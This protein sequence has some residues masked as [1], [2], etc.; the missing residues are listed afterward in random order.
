MRSV[1]AGFV[2]AGLLLVACKN[3]TSLTG[4][5]GGAGGTGGT[6]GAG[7]S[8]ELAKVDKVDLL[9][10]IDNSRSMAD[11]QTILSLALSDLVSGLANPPCLDETGNYVSQPGALSPCPEGSSRQY[12]PVRDIHIGVVTSSLGGHGSDAC[13]AKPGNHNDDRAHLITRTPADDGSN[14]PTYQDLGFLAWDPE[15]SLAPPGLADEALLV[16]RF[17]DLVLGVGQTG[18]GFEAQ[19]ESWYR[20]LV[21]PDPPESLVVNQPGEVEW[22][23]SDNVLLAQ[24]KAFLRPDSMLAIVSMSDENDCSIREESAYYYVAQAMSGAGMFHLPKARAICETDPAHECCYSCAGTSPVDA[25]GN[26]VCEGDPTCT[27]MFGNVPYHD[28][29]TD[30]INQRCFDQKRRFGIDF[31]YPLDRYV[32]GLT[33]KLVP[34]RNGNLVDNPLFKDLD[35]TDGEQPVRDAG[36]VLLTGIVGVPWQDIAKNP[37]DLKQGFK[38]AGE[39]TQ[40]NAAGQTTWDI[41][42]GDPA[43]YTLPLDPFMQESIF[44]RSGQNPVTGDSITTSG[45]DNPINGHDYKN[46]AQD[47]L[48]YACV[49]PIPEP[50]DCTA[51]VE[52]C[53]C[54]A[55]NDLPLCAP[56]PADN[57]NPT[58]QVRAKAM[59]GLRQLGVLRGVGERGIIGSICA[60]QLQNP[61]Q[62]DFAYRPVVASLLDRMKLRLK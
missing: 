24:R 10:A 40:K 54:A 42:L 7:G 14:V 19:L 13:P 33:D 29:T 41:I 21:Q 1:L 16:D 26:P 36:L 12:Q 47:D 35:T 27:D 32:S 22:V 8:G 5:P 37:N 3:T 4:D 48:Q 60:V 45:E 56:N 34:D 58:L 30:H 28:D 52:S 44:P 38:T 49:M 43:T 61:E 55:D 46:E 18:C 11:K 20:F 39:L 53:D 51:L 50:R 6:G 15:Q 59:P 57:N 9:F 31:L 2:I 17:S 23:G 25:N 62:P